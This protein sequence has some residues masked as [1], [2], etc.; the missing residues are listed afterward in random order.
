MNKSKF[1]YIANHLLEDAV[2][3]VAIDLNSEPMKLSEPAHTAAIVSKFPGLMNRHWGVAKF[4]GC[5]IHQSPYV[6]FKTKNRK[7]KSE[8]CEVGDLLCLCKKIVDGIIRYNATLFQLK[9]DKTESG[10]VKPDNVSQRLLYTEWP[11]FSFDHSRANAG[12][13]QYDIQPK[14]VTPGAQYMFINKY[15]Y[16]CYVPVVFTHSIPSSVMENTPERSFGSFLWDFINWQNGRPI[17][18]PDANPKD[19]WSR[20]IWELVA[21]TTNKVYNI[22]KS[23]PK[24]QICNLRS[25]GDFFAFMTKMTD[26]AYG[27]FLYA[28]WLKKEYESSLESID[29]IKDKPIEG[30]GQSVE[31]NTSD[32]ISILFID[33]DKEN[34]EKLSEMSRDTSKLSI[35]TSCV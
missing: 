21:R 17:S 23:N 35:L 29:Y 12:A 31:V 1:I 19:E 18:E 5:F 27:D 3:K 16:P 9:K 20:L 15:S 26:G 8:R 2:E 6:N 25:N 33:F 34:E 22:N 4:G 32:G 11:V 7:R 30:D 28:E 13:N 14:A 10:K 24:W